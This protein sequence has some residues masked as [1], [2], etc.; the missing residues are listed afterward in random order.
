MSDAG[1][2]LTRECRLFCRYLADLDATPEIVRAYR[3]AHEIEGLNIGATTPIDRALLRL[4]AGGRTLTRLA[5]SF[6]AVAAR[7]SALRKKLVVLV[8]ILESRGPSAAAIDRASPGSRVAWV[9]GAALQG[10][11]WLLRFVV[12]SLLLV[13]LR[14]WYGTPPQ[15]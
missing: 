2:H 7:N 13:P 15:R 14:L 3:S 4:A 9:I 10:G 5:D 11:G 6:A 8:A 12:A 1:D